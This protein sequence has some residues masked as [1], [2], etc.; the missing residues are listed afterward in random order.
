[1][2]ENKKSNETGISERDH[3]EICLLYQN[4]A[5]NLSTLKKSQWQVYVF[6]S[7]VVAFLLLKV[8]RQSDPTIKVLISLLL[9]L[10]VIA[11]EFAQAYFRRDMLNFR[12][13]LRDIY[14]NFGYLFRE[15]RG[16]AKGE[17][18]AELNSFEK[19][20]R[21][22]GCVYSFAVFSYAMVIFWIEELKKIYGCVLL[23]TFL[24]IVAIVPF[25]MDKC[26]NY[27]DKKTKERCS[28]T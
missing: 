9:L 28:K 27:I 8:N 19:I 16:S 26:V 24:V 12:Q 21:H 13:I 15:I 18:K 3:V 4:A 5:A 2:I 20:F 17:K 11:V 14:K 25:V 6:Y 7:A 23:I 10:G 1:M 22:G